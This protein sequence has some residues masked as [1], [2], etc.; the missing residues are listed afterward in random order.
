[1]QELIEN[2]QSQHQEFAGQGQPQSWLSEMQHSGLTQL[3]KAGFPTL[4]DENWRYTNVKPLL[5][6]AFNVVTRAENKLSSHQLDSFNIDGLESLKIIIVDGQFDAQLS[7]QSLPPGLTLK[8][9]SDLLD[10]HAGHAANHINKLLPESTHGFTALNTAFV[11]D[12]VWIE[13]DKDANIEKPIE[14][15]FI[16]TGQDHALVQPRNLFIAGENSQFKVIE[17]LSIA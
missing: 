4:A 7:T 16:S 5:K 12:G 14:L 11:K 13:T 6:K 9:L 10:Q 2:Y 1:M 8:S 15:I 17:R 3:G